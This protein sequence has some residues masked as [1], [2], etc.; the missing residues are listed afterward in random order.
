MKY[1]FLRNIKLNWYLRETLG[2]YS[3][4]SYDIS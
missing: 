1:Q 4:T 3:L 2:P